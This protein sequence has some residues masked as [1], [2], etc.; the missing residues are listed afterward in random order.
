ME[1]PPALTSMLN[2]LLRTHGSIKSWNIY[3]GD[4]GIVNVNIRF[5]DITGEFIMPV[6]EP[7][8]YKRVS[9]RQLA[10]NKVRANQ[11]RENHDQKARK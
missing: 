4:N 1:M 10:C 7:V 3:Q 9:S 8:S 5:S 6:E 11:C 2:H